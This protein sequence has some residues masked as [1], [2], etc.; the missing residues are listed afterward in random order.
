MVSPEPTRPPIVDEGT[1]LIFVQN[2]ITYTV[3]INDSEYRALMHYDCDNLESSLIYGT[4]AR[5]ANITPGGITVEIEAI[6][7]TVMHRAII[8]RTIASN[9]ARCLD[10]RE[11]WGT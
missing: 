3:I 6:Y 4:I 10:Q 11:K 1:G 2:L 9:I 5:A 8:A 7:D